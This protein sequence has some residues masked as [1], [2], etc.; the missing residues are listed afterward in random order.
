MRTRILI[1]AGHEGFQRALGRYLSMLDAGSEVVGAAGTA[2][3]VLERAARL[4]ADIAL[5]DLDRRERD[6]LALTGAIRASSPATGVIVVGTL[7]AEDYRRAALVA[8][9]AEYID[10]FDLV[11]RLPA[12]LPT[13]A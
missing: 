3:E 5:I 1:V 11:E 7:L 9:A 10:K 4:R 6:G 13:V 8:G 12:A 2:V